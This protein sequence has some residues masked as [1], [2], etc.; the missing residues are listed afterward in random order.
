MVG[1]GG[2]PVFFITQGRGQDDAVAEGQAVLRVQADGF[3]FAVGEGFVRI[4]AARIGFADGAGQVVHRQAVARTGGFRMFVFGTGNDGLFDR[5]VKFPHAASGQAAYHLLEAVI[6]IA[7]RVAQLARAHAGNADI[8]GIVF[9]AQFLLI[10]G[11]VRFFQ[12]TFARIAVARFNALAAD[13]VAGVA[14]R[15]HHRYRSARL[16][17]QAVC[18]HGVVGVVILF[19]QGF[20]TVAF[21]AD[22]A[23]CQ[24]IVGIVF[25]RIGGGARSRVAFVT[26]HVFR[27]VSLTARQHQQ[28]FGVFMET[29]GC[30]RYAVAA[31]A[32]A[33]AVFQTEMTAFVRIDEITR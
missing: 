32:A 22:T 28:T 3:A 10:G 16:R 30:R 4:G 21:V 18:Q 33:V 9:R 29:G 31:V 5:A 23:F 17:T 1:F 27:F 20:K 6:G 15:S 13:A 19:V 7:G 26:A 24:N 8:D 2:Q 12:T 11:Q 14:F 25:L